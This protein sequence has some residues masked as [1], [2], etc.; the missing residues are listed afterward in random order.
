[1]IK[2]LED[3]N[4]SAAREWSEVRTEIRDGSDNTHRRPS[5]SISVEASR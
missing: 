5:V 3:T 2:H 1:M 4:T